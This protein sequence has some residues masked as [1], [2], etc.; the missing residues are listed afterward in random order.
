MLPFL[1]HVAGLPARFAPTLLPRRATAALRARQAVGGRR[2][3]RVGG[4]PLARGQL[5]LQ[6]G[7]LLLGV[8]D[9]PI[10]FDYLLAELLNLMLLLLDLPLQFIPAGRM[11]VRMSARRYL[12][13]ACASSGSRTLP[14]YGKRFRVI[15]P[16][17]IGRDTG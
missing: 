6:I 1:S 2:L 5:P 8:V 16:A 4:I 7:D 10:P 12:L 14:P 15:C 11:R 9:L 17:D 13:I 3:G